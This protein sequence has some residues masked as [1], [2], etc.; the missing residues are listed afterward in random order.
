GPGGAGGGAGGGC[1]RAPTNPALPRGDVEK[2]LIEG[3]FPHTPASAVPQRQRTVGLQELGLPYA[4]D[5]AVSKHL[6]WFLA[7]NDEVLNQTGGKKRKKKAGQQPAVILFNGGVFKAQPLR[8][9]LLEILNKWS[10]ND[11]G[12]RELEGADLDRAV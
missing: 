8:S 6:A 5:P 2:V 9:R 7:R 4:A 1:G 10:K 3:F 12:V 11:A